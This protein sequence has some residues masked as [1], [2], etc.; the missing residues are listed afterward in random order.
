[1]PLE[2]DVPPCGLD[3]GPRH[4]RDLLEG[5][6]GQQELAHAAGRPREPEVVVGAREGPDRR[7]RREPLAA[8]RHLAR[9]DLEQAQFERR[10]PERPAGG[11]GLELLA[12]RGVVALEHVDESL[13]HGTVGGLA[14]RA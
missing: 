10:I 9:P 7:E 3:V 5:V 11:H 13:R 2:E 8:L 1:M 14:S 12:R 6:V 4:V